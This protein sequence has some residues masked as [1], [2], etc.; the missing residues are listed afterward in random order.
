MSRFVCTITIMALEM[1]TQHTRGGRSAQG[2]AALACAWALLISVQLAYAPLSSRRSLV[3]REGTQVAIILGV[4]V[5]I[6]LAAVLVSG[7]PARAVRI[8]AGAIFIVFCLIGAAS[9]GLLYLPTAVL[10][11]IAAARTPSYIEH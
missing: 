3:D 8:A 4:L 6:A 9:I 5:L 1:T 10:L 2:F 7:R 11:F